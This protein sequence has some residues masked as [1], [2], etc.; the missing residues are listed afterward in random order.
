VYFVPALGLAA[1]GTWCS[2][3]NDITD[4]SAYTLAQ[5]QQQQM[6]ML[7]LVCQSTVWCSL[8]HH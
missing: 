8:L 6:L 3:Q 1:A 5:Q 4:A 7:E 2:Y